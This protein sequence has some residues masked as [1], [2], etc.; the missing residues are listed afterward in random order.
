MEKVKRE[1]TLKTS[2][3]FTVI[4]LLTNLVF[5]N[6]IN[7]IFI[8]NSL[9]FICILFYIIFVFRYRTNYFLFNSLL[10]I[11]IFS[12]IFGTFLIE[13]FKEQIYLDELLLKGKEIGSIPL[14]VTSHI[15]FLELA[16]LIFKKYKN[17]KYKYERNKK[18]III[19]FLT[20][21]F[22]LVLVYLY[23]EIIKDGT[24]IFHH[25][26]KFQ[27]QQ[28]YMSF[29]ELRLSNLICIFPVILGYIFF[30][31][32]EKYSLIV[33]IFLNVYFICIGQKFS[34][35]I[36]SFFYFF[37]YKINMIKK[38]NKKIFFILCILGVFLIALVLLQYKN[39]YTQK[40]WEDIFLHFFHRLAQQ[41]QLW[42]GTYIEVMDK[43][44]SNFSEIVNE[45]KLIFYKKEEL[46]LKTGIYKIMFL[47]APEDV[48]I[49]AYS[50][51]VRY[52]F[53]SQASFLYYFSSL[54]LLLMQIIYGVIYGTILG[55][56]KECLVK[57]KVITLILL[58]RV[59]L[60]ANQFYLQSDFY[61]ILSIKMFAV[62][63]LIFLISKLEGKYCIKRI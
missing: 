38:I 51:G 26:N 37:L 53:S 18:D 43:H 58:S 4:L 10:I 61:K 41:G 34:F 47:V 3:I 31:K 22:L 32:G 52:A 63:I 8:K 9:S 56:I 57:N 1:K 6:L 54:G 17:F 45:I 20:I 5:V 28:R 50:R 25:V 44:T 60:Y 36:I 27:Y 40:S 29:I 42:W 24:S 62:Y 14:L 13:V 59:Y 11:Y 23:F 21:F 49:G 33:Y 16:Y 46:I 35:L 7:S 48:V 12:N 15:L 30:K 39:N 19:K 2:I 55:K